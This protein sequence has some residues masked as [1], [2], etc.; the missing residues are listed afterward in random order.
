MIE[1]QRPVRSTN[2]YGQSVERWVFFASRRA[3]ILPVSMSEQE[4]FAALRVALSHSVVI[5]FCSG[6]SPDMRIFWPATGRIFHIVEI[7]TDNTFRREMTLKV[8]EL[9]TAYQQDQ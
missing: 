5:R 9:F 4:S 1:I 7:K 3:A 6:L 8:N 2:E